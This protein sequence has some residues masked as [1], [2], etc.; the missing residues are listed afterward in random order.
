MLDTLLGEHETPFEAR[1][2]GQV[3][4]RMAG[5]LKMIVRGLRIRESG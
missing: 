1:N 2:V 5:Q 4:P 3:M